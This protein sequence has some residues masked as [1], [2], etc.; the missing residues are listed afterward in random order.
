MIKKFISADQINN[1]SGLKE[2]FYSRI[3]DCSSEGSCWEWSGTLTNWGYGRIV[4]KYHLESAHR[5]SYRLHTGE[6]IPKGLCV[7]HSCDNKKCVN[8][9]HLWLGTTQENTKDRNQKNRV[10]K[11]LKHS[12]A[13]RKKTPVGE[14]NASAKLTAQNVLEIVDMRQNKVPYKTIA[15]RFGVSIGCLEGIMWGYNWTHVT[16]FPKKEK[17]GNFSE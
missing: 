4:F 14:R 12:L 16:K 11:G 15:E 8:P 3:V 7:C 10:S 17:R 6:E 1:T 13:T 2:A 9:A 5:F